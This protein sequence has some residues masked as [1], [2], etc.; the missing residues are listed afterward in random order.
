MPEDTD[1]NISADREPY[2]IKI[3]C[4][5]NCRSAKRE[6]CDMTFITEKGFRKTNEAKPRG[7]FR[8]LGVRKIRIN[9]NRGKI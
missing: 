6:N 1:P 4:K 5:P 2:T 3:L 9:L 8:F 7:K